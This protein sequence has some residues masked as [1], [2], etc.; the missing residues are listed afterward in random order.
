[1]ASLIRAICFLFL[2]MMK[3]YQQA[4]AQGVNIRG[5]WI[6]DWSGIIKTSFG[7]RVFWNWQWNA[8]RYPGQ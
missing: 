5:L 3:R 8:T 6:Q 7:Q 1:M 4:K 2:Q